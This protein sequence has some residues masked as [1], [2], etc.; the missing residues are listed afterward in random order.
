MAQA[1]RQAGNIR[2]NVNQMAELARD[3][4]LLNEKEFNDAWRYGVDIGSHR[5]EKVLLAR[6][7]AD[8]FAI[9]RK[10]ATAPVELPK[11]SYDDPVR[12]YAT[13]RSN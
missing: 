5:S 4:G 1:Y 6:T 11:R 13:L 7:A 3:T 2:N 9:Y 10:R 8:P 12:P